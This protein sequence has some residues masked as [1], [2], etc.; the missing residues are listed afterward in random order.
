MVMD[1]HQRCAFRS[2]PAAVCLLLLLAGC[3]HDR[4]V[5]DQGVDETPTADQS[6]TVAAEI[7]SESSTADA[8]AESDDEE[9]LAAGIEADA[10]SADAT[11]ATPTTSIDAAQDDMPTA[12]VQADTASSEANESATADDEESLA[13]AP[14]VLPPVVKVPEPEVGPTESTMEACDDASYPDTTV[15]ER[16]RRRLTITACASSAWLDGLFGNQLH[17]DDYRATYGSVSVGSLWSEY[18]GFDPRMRFRARLQLPQWNER[19]SAFAGRVGEEDYIS[20]TEGDFDALPTR[21]FGGVEDESVLLGLGYSSPSR[22]GN[23]FDAGVGVRVD[24]PL[25]PYAQVRYELVR[26]FADNYVFRARETVF[27]RNSEGFGS[28]TRFNIDRALS[29]RFLLRFNN[30]GKY[31][32]ET[33]GLEWISEVSLFQSIGKRTGLAWQTYITGVTDNEV[34]LTR[35]GAR[36]IMRRQLSTEWLFL[37]VRGGIGWPRMHLHE[38][39]EA[40]PEAGIALEM[41]FG[42]KEGR[43][44]L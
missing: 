18:D 42:K 43:R 1:L 31:T 13:A 24:M 34:P 8:E 14:P 10:T 30:L 25:D 9:I 21:Q 40:S 7:Q 5:D 39:R 29:N 37:E 16:V 27:W 12:A 44:G 41:Q 35:Y 17:Y 20:D 23:D 32:E 36:L 15:L 11:D 38:R 4:S 26:T 19:I 3:A 28:T 22:T 33:L 2:G 6:T